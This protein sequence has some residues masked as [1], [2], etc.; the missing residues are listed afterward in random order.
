MTSIINVTDEI[1]ERQISI[2]ELANKQ[3]IF[4]NDINSIRKDKNKFRAILK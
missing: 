3:G 2:D 1:N 4:S